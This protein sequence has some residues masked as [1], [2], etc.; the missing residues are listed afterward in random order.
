MD[1]TT[2]QLVNAV[3]QTGISALK[4]TNKGKEMWMP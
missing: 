4:H 1:C 3:C 2:Y